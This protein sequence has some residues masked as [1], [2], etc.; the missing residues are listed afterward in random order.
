MDRSRGGDASNFFNRIKNVEVLR[1]PYPRHLAQ[2]T[3]R[4]GMAASAR[5]IIGGN[6]VP[7]NTM[8][9]A[10]T[11]AAPTW[12]SPPPRPDIVNS[13]H[14]GGCSSSRS[15]NS[16][17]GRV[18]PSPALYRPPPEYPNSVQP[19]RVR[20]YGMGGDYRHIPGSTFPSHVSAGLSTARNM[21]PNAQYC[22]LRNWIVCVDVD[23]MAV[24]VSGSFT[25]P[26]GNTV[27]RHSSSIEMAIDER[28]LRASS[29]TVYQLVDTPDLDLMRSKGFPEYLI[30][31]FVDGFPRNWKRLVDEY[32]AVA[33]SAQR[34]RGAPLFRR[35][36]YPL[37][38]RVT[39][40]SGNLHN[41]HR[42]LDPSSGRFRHGSDGGDAA[43]I[44]PSTSPTGG[45]GASSHAGTRQNRPF[46]TVGNARTQANGAAMVYRSGADIFAS[47]R[48]SRVGGLHTPV[49][50]PHEHSSEMLR[51][52]ERYDPDGVNDKDAVASAVDDE[53]Q[54]PS[55]QRVDSEL[56]AAMTNLPLETPTKGPSSAGTGDMLSDTIS[57]ELGAT[58]GPPWKGFHGSH[59]ALN[60][61]ASEPFKLD[62]D[63]DDDSQSDQEDSVVSQ[64]PDSTIGDSTEDLPQNSSKQKLATRKPRRTSRKIVE[65][66]DEGQS[67]PTAEAD[68]NEPLAS[69]PVTRSRIIS[70]PNTD[71]VQRPK[72]NAASATRKPALATPGKR[73]D[74]SKVPNSAP[75]G[76][77]KATRG[78][79]DK[80][81]ARR[82][83]KNVLT[84]TE[85]TPS[86]PP[87][88]KKSTG[89]NYNASST[90]KA[91]VVI[92]PP[93][94]L[95][96]NSDAGSDSE[97]S[98]PLWAVV[99]SQQQS[100]T[101]A[102]TE[103]ADEQDETLPAPAADGELPLP[104][105][106]PPIQESPAIG[107]R[108]ER[109]PTKAA[110]S[111]KAESTPSKWRVG[112]RFFKYKEFEATTSVTR[113]G[114]KVRRP[115]QWWANAQEH[116]ATTH[117]E[118]AIKY[119]WGTGDAVVVKDGKRMRLSDVFLEGS[120][121][122]LSLPDQNTDDKGEAAMS[123]TS[124]EA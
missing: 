77:A 38:N 118:S 75:A 121:A 68:A 73:K 82:T 60:D 120:S 29:G 16:D 51:S 15:H 46:D 67:Q 98:A 19:I 84:S 9:P 22:V 112:R 7:H 5:P 34:G 70:K 122:D 30:P 48:F 103:S 56:A 57:P 85:Q 83:P 123:D 41:E 101:K 52:S 113:S 35:D 39:S 6:V 69:T 81:T 47:G 110:P 76:R 95:S 18:P 37:M 107:G 45:Y 91:M 13:I 117:K 44:Q 53:R 33:A 63:A 36:D 58:N 2:N 92:E 3:Q 66:S 55:M 27:A 43:D 102:T 80:R 40:P 99:E 108:S 8:R 26:N 11:R 49:R 28:V 109:T 42:A 24:T 12:Q 105:P 100:E 61:D 32:L 96:G 72:S 124:N 94:K 71:S 86:K 59:M 93:A 17:R 54:I 23:K 62:D 87:R 50:A 111:V 106:S 25:K 89:R 115:Q 79:Q 64:P 1:S 88:T 21:P 10:P 90:S 114:R 74:L 97:A 78:T 31:Y 4:P 65:S 116:L 104:S 20:P 119:R 14:T